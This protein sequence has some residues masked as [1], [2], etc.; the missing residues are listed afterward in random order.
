MNP[1]GSHLVLVNH[2]VFA[3]VGVFPVPCLHFLEVGGGA[4]AGEGGPVDVLLA[5]INMT[6][7]STTSCITV[8]L[9]WLGLQGE[10][11][12]NAPAE[13]RWLK[14]VVKNVVLGVV[15]I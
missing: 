9:V 2:C 5:T 3:Q 10:G 4:R 8:I 15:A 1:L 13:T 14:Y 7:T 11:D 6:T 12:S